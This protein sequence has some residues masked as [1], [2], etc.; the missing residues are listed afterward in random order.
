MNDDR[1]LFDRVLQQALGGDTSFSV[2]RCPTLVP[3]SERVSLKLATFAWNRN[4]QLKHRS[5]DDGPFAN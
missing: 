2:G 1:M 5:Y 3:S 4:G